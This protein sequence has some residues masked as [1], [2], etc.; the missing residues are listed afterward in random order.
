MAG[1]EPDPQERASHLRMQEILKLIKLCLTVI[2]SVK[3]MSMEVYLKNWEAEL[4]E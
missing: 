2:L 1:S 3:R 4:G